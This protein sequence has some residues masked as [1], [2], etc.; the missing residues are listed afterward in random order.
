MLF[1]RL[2]FFFFSFLFCSRFISTQ[3]D[4]E[5]YRLWIRSFFTLEKYLTRVVLFHPK[6]FAYIEMKAEW[7]FKYANKYACILHM[8]KNLKVL[9]SQKYLEN[10]NILTSKERGERILNYISKFLSSKY[11]D[12]TKLWVSNIFLNNL[13][14]NKMKLT[15]CKVKKK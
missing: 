11:F 12:V 7:N 2:S 9:K 13:F 3:S 1:G 8:C 6:N 14:I 5:P 4:I 10:L 15:N